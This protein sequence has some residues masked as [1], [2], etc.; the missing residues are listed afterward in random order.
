MPLLP[1]SPVRIG[2]LNSAALPVSSSQVAHESCTCCWM[3]GVWN[4]SERTRQS[5]TMRVYDKEWGR[6]E[7]EAR[8]EEQARPVPAGGRSRRC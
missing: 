2:S 1:Q 7:E 4:T 6:E 3:H 8:V 5:I